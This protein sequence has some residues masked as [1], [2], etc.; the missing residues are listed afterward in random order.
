MALIVNPSTKKKKY[1]YKSADLLEAKEILN[2]E[3]FRTI[4][5]QISFSKSL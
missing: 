1:L 4:H 2:Q 5:E 3:L